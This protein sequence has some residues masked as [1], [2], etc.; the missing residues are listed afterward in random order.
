[1]TPEYTKICPTGILLSSGERNFFFKFGT[2][3]TPPQQ[4]SSSPTKSK[5]LAEAQAAVFQ[6]L[7]SLQ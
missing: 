6:I 7:L 3:A 2:F 4:R 1:M 5:I